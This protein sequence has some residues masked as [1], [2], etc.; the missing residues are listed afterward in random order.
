[1]EDFVRIISC[2][3]HNFASYKH[4]EFNFNDKGLCLVAGPTGSG[5][6][7]LCDVV[8]WILFGKTAKGGSVDEVLSWPGHEV[9][10]GTLEFEVN[11]I[12]YKIIR[13]RGKNSKD[14]DLYIYSFAELSLDHRRGKDLLDTQKIVN[15]VLGFDLDLYLSG[16]YFHEFSQTAQF[17]STT[18]KNRRL[19]TEQLVDLSL[20]RKLQESL[21]ATKK[22][23]TI[24]LNAVVKE[25]DTLTSNIALLQRMQEAETT[26]ESRWHEEHRKTISYV[27]SLYNKFEVNRERTV[28]NKCNSCGTAL[29]AP[30]T[31]VDESTNPHLERLVELE[32]EKNP[33]SGS[34]KDFTSEID[35]I[36]LKQTLA[37]AQLT[38]CTTYLNDL[39]LLDNVTTDFRAVLIRNTVL[40]LE[41]HTNKLLTDHFD[42]EIRVQFAAEDADKLDT[43]IFK[44]G[45]E[46]TFTQL[47]KGQRQLL[48]LS[49][50]LAVMKSIQNHHGISFNAVFL[51]E[52]LDGLDETLKVKA[53]GLLQSLALYYESVF[54]V[55]HNEA[56]KSMFPN[57]IDVSLTSEG[58]QLEEA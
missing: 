47:S 33:H 49:F 52:A 45:N 50:G 27:K 8:P 20:A 24:K 54:V 16:A 9:T 19:I 7:T 37:N 3:V 31:I 40:D 26:K 53:Y 5:K 39:E 6:S 41:A 2:E 28:S 22:T 58:S 30:T 14:N 56:L 48:K 25:F 15:S 34:V 43:T 21:S 44:D 42:A 38:V 10:T 13:T 55:E 35:G 11:N 18:A 4:L 17:F 46:C 57:R 36:N 23:I 32:Q 29:K 51:D 1:L 12:K